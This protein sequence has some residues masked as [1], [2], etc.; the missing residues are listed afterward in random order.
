[1]KHLAATDPGA[2]CG[3]GTGLDDD[4]DPAH[5]LRRGTHGRGARLTRRCRRGRGGCP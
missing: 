4:V 3:R 1:V 2:L 5:G